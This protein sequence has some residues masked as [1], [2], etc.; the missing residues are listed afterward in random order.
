MSPKSFEATMS[1]LAC[2]IGNIERTPPRS[3]SDLTRLDL[4]VSR[5][6]TAATKAARK[7]ENEN[8]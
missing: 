4:L 7:M 3:K 1:D 6:D 2:A 8:V 5:L